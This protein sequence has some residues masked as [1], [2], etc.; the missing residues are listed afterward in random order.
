[1]ACRLMHA[2][3]PSRVSPASLAVGVLRSELYVAAE[4]VDLVEETE[5]P[6]GRNHCEQM[7]LDTKVCTIQF[8][9][10]MRRWFVCR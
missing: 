3:R 2:N 8:C 7:W 1:M 9:T 6:V 4:A 10:Q 5:H